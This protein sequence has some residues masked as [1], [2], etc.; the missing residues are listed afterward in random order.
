MNVQRLCRSFFCLL[1]G[2]LL[3]LCACQKTE[4]PDASQNSEPQSSMIESS[5]PLPTEPEPEPEPI[6][7]RSLTS[8]RTY[9]EQ[10]DFY[11]IMV[12][13]ENSRDA[14]P[15]TGLMQADVIYEAPVESTITRFACLFND[16]LPVVAGP[17]RSVRM[18]YLGI[19]QE[20]DCIFMHYGGPDLSGSEA[21]VYGSKY[22]YVRVRLNG[23][24]GK[25][26]DYFWR[27]SDR[28]A[29]HNVYTDLTYV[30][31]QYPDYVCSRTQHWSFGDTPSTSA[32]SAARVH[33][34]FVSSKEPNVEFVYDAASKTYLRY[35]NGEPFYT[36]TVDASG[37]S[38]K[39]QV[40]VNNLIVQYIS[41]RTL[42]DADHHRII[43]MIGSGDCEIF[44]QGKQISG[45]WERTSASDVTHYYDA[46]GREITFAAG[47]TWVALQPDS[48]TIT[49][50][51]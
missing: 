47:N 42:N 49:V 51:P 38:E 33:I 46:Y 43:N 16:T 26:D 14:R 39:Q 44:I 8:G 9:A 34:P 17:V 10:P 3:C 36:Y 37:N 31:E 12:M 48:K 11:P 22:D 32:V 19:Q 41:M 25:Y 5:L 6:V 7:Y 29:P 30:K 15:Q 35:E 40:A 50:T 21:T 23:I 1:L 4:Q 45:S 28:K 27:S 2:A 13:I 20:W 24:W 18:Y